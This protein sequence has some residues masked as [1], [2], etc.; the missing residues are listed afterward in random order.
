M[1]K[2]IARRRDVF[3]SG[4]GKDPAPGMPGSAEP[5]TAS[6]VAMAASNPAA[7]MIREQK[8]RRG[9]A[10]CLSKSKLLSL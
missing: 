1:S 6:R 9:L 7:K 3:A 4:V 5:K 8:Y 2:K 10:K